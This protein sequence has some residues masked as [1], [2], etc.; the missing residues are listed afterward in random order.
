M[1]SESTVDMNSETTT[2]NLEAADS[3][4]DSENADNQDGREQVVV[5]EVKEEDG[6]ADIAALRAEIDSL[7]KQV[8]NEHEGFLRARADYT[9]LKRRS[10]EERDTLRSYVTGDLLVRL[11]PVID[12]FERALQAAEQTRDYDKLI[13]GVEAVY[14]QVQTFL[15][16]EGVVAIETT[17]QPFDPNL[18][19]A[20]LRD[21]ESDLPENTVV[22]ELQKGYKLGDRVLRAAMVKV[23][24]GNK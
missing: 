4:M 15:Q 18:H 3:A 24:V 10:E 22:A 11:L 1:P 9:N 19:E 7:K 14:K 21:E 12:N 17:N 16:K 2:E 8:E 6:T 23:A 20:V 5:G 13:G